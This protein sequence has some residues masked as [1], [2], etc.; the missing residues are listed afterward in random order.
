MWAV[1]TSTLLTVAVVGWAS[2]AWAQGVALT[3]PSVSVTDLQSVVSNC[4]LVA[5]T[6][7]ES[8][9]SPHAGLCFNSGTAY[10]EALSVVQPALD[11]EEF[12]QRI[13][14]LVTQLAPLVQLNE[15]CDAVDDEVARTIRAASAYSH[16]DE[17]RARLEEI[18]ATIASCD[19]GETAAIIPEEIDASPSQ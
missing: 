17:Q 12:D 15:A 2:L 1:R 11:D 7:D 8:G 13:A 4:E 16:S 10:L 9:Q 3:D 6:A 19:I 5:S 14:D 18:A